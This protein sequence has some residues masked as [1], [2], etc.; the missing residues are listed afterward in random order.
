MTNTSD[1]R[2]QSCGMPLDQGWFGVEA[3][4]SFS[5][6]YCKYCYQQGVF[7]KPEL[8]LAQALDLSASHMKRVLHMPEADAKMKANEMIPKLKRWMKE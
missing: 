5:R 6:D 2:C 1:M 7:T 3:D 8:T 4:G